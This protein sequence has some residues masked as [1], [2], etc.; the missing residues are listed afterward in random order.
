MYGFTII[1]IWINIFTF[2]TFFIFSA[3]PYYPIYITP[4]LPPPLFISIC[5]NLKF[6]LRILL[7]SNFRKLRMNLYYYFILNSILSASYYD[8]FGYI[9]IVI[10]NFLYSYIPFTFIFPRYMSFLLFETRWSSTIIHSV[11]IWNR[12]FPNKILI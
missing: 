2:E 3:S 5:I 7:E 12:Y 10:W 9:R 4:P 1:M 6:W 8:K 11:F